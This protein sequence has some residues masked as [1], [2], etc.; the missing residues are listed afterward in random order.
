MQSLR[1]Y[2]YKEEVVGNFPDFLFGHKHG[3]NE[4]HND[5]HSGEFHLHTNGINPSEA[6]FRIG[7]A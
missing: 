7:I 3:D 5:T 2:F 6:S 1:P 4:Y